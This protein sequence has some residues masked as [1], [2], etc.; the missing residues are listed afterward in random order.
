MGAGTEE[1]EGSIWEA[2]FSSCWATVALLTWGGKK[3]ELS[4]GRGKNRGIKGGKEGTKWR[5]RG[6]SGSKMGA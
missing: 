1:R 4:R 6:E 3:G 2:A 5:Q